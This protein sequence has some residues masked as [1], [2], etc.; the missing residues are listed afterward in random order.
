MILLVDDQPAILRPLSR[1][2]TSYGYEVCAVDS[3]RRALEQL[4]TRIP[5]C[6]ICDYC[7]P[8]MDGLELIRSIRAQRQYD[9]VRLIMFTSDESA[10][11]EAAALAAGADAFVRKG[12][13][14][15]AELERAVRAHCGPAAAPQPYRPPAA[16][17]RRNKLG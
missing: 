1:L 4:A 14:D 15:F 8:A 11:L 12:T 17:S 13:L 16:R 2:L 7:M 5:H 9:A 6:I 10:G 3:A